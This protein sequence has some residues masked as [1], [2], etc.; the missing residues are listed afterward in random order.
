MS[1]TPNKTW[2]KPKPTTPAATGPDNIVAPMPVTAAPNPVTA[3]LVVV[4]FFLFKNYF[5]PKN[6]RHLGNC[7]ARNPAQGIQ[8]CY[9]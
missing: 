4:P 6:F 8:N 5:L 9:R 2:A 3:Q 7:F 1:A